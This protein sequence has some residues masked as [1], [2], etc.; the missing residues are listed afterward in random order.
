MKRA[1]AILLALMMLLSLAACAAKNDAAPSTSG[2]DAAPAQ[3]DA[4]ADTS[5]AA[6]KP[7][8]GKTLTVNFGTHID[9][10]TT[11]AFFDKIL[12]AFEEQTGA[13]VEVNL[14]AYADLNPKQTADL[15]AQD[16]ADILFITGGSEYE[17]IANGYICDLTDKYDADTVSDWIFWENKAVNGA[18]YVVPFSGGCAY[19]C[20]ILN[21]TLCKELGLEVP[22][23]DA[24]TWDVVKEYG[25]AAVAAGYKGLT[26]PFS[27][28]ENAIICN[29]FQYVNEAG[30]SL[31]DENGLYDFTSPEA[32]KAMTFIYDMFNT[33][34]IID[35]VAYDATSC[36]DEFV[37]GNALFCSQSA[38]NWDELALQKNIVDFEWDI[39][40]LRDVRN[41]SFNTADAFAINASSKN[42]DLAA[43]FVKYFMSTDTYLTYRNV[44]SFDSACVKSAHPEDALKDEFKH[45]LE[46]DWVFFPPSCPGAAEIKLALQTHQQLCAL[47]EETPEQ[48]LAEIQKV[49]DSYK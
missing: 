37:L 49:A 26:S 43:A 9:E 16:A 11:V 34:K 18:H 48:A 39:Y 31:A 27:G 42:I 38:A 17:Y 44:L 33:D 8:A 6:E 2:S 36:I 1:I 10:P 41:G 45:L 35:T 46:T 12:P 25:K 21:T 15:I 20:Y 4:P 30:G 29:Y 19:R 13:K 22:A 3:A 23:H 24:L 32:L 14:M 47:G 5:A 28:N 40:N 7:Y